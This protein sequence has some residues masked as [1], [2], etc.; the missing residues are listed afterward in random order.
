MRGYRRFSTVQQMSA[1]V[2]A[3]VVLALVLESGGLV[4]WGQRLDLGPERTVALPVVMAL[5]RVLGWTRMDRVRREE[6]VELAR[7]GWSDDPEA[8][9]IARKE[10]HIESK[11]SAPPTLPV[12]VE[13]TMDAKP[14][15][16]PSIP[17]VKR[18]PM[19]GDPPLLST[20]PE[21]PA[22]EAGQKRT[23]A[24][25]GDSMMAVGISSTLLREAPKYPD[26]VLDK[27]F[28]SGTGLARPEVFNWQAEYPAMIGD[29][30][31]DMVVVAIGANDGQ[32]FVEDGVTYPFGS[33]GWMRIYRA[34]VEAFLAMLEA[35]GATVVWMG[36]PPMKSDAYD[37]RIAVV[38]RIDYEVVSESPQAI[39][40]S[41][42]GIVGDGNGKFQDFGQV[43]G[44]T[45]RLRQADGIH[46]SDDGAVLVVAQ[47]LPW[48]AAQQVAL[49]KQ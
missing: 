16:A 20:L 27:A 14:S 10:R 48:L 7:I 17:R 6:L 41:T 1:S 49:S 45:A 5:H 36:L 3:F 4:D 44:A 35:D 30:H 39:W 11:P 34:R 33:A 38:N 43:R 9:A 12:H 22:V 37:A 15:A 25:V 42:A 13:G 24:L 23:V 19:E 46:L 26:L 21:I 31:P 28:K 29:A 8:L 40:Y 47:L 2:A 18:K 32:G